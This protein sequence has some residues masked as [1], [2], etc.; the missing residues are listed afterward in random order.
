MAHEPE[1]ALVGIELGPLA[2]H[3]GALHF[4]LGKERR[5]EFCHGLWKAMT[6]P[7]ERRPRRY[8]FR[9]ADAAE[10]VGHYY[11]GV[12]VMPSRLSTAIRLKGRVSV[13]LGRTS[14]HIRNDRGRYEAPYEAITQHVINAEGQLSSL[15]FGPEALIPGVLHLGFDKGGIEFHGLVAEARRRL[16]V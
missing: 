4:F 11:D 12:S 8:T 7:R 10:G 5:K 6:S 15:E 16:G 3:P 13:R 1:P 14:L 9:E 2:A